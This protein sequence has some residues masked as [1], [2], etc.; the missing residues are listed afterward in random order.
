MVARLVGMTARF[1]TP[2]WEVTGAVI[3]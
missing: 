2:R 3:R 1:L